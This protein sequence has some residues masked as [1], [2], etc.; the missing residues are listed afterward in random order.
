M[1]V[2]VFQLYGPIRHLFRLDNSEDRLKMTTKQYLRVLMK[3][4]VT[5]ITSDM[6]AVN[7]EDWLC[8]F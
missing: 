8:V 3:T 1:H 4:C 7:C 2:T 6:L 5:N